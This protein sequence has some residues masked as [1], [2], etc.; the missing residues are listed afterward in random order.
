MTKVFTPS[1]PEI[2]AF[3]LSIVI[4]QSNESIIAHKLSK[5]LNRSTPLNSIMLLLKQNL[6]F[7]FLYLNFHIEDLQKHNYYYR[8]FFLMIPV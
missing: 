6:I 2:C 4:T 8:I 7:L 3:I 1:A 5:S